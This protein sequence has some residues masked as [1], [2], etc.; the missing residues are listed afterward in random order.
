MNQKPPPIKTASKL[1]RQLFEKAQ[2]LGW[3]DS[4]IATKLDHCN[5]YIGSWRRGDRNMPVFDAEVFAHQLGVE[6]NLGDTPKESL[7]TVAAR[8]N[9]LLDRFTFD[10]TGYN[11]QGGNGGLITKETMQA[12]DKLRMALE[13]VKEAENG[14]N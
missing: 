12:A 10:V 1:T 7:S 5:T 4:A 6:I 13:A 11:G 14:K 2:S 3:T 8:A 9:D